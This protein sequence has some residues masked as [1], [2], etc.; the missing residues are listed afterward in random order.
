LIA[1][2]N[3]LAGAARAN[4]QGVAVQTEQGALG[5]AALREQVALAADVLQQKGVGLGDRVAILGAPSLGWVVAFHAVGWLGA[6]AQPVP[7]NPGGQALLTWLNQA[8]SDWLLSDEALPPG[9]LDK[10]IALEL[11]GGE[12]PVAERDWPLDEVRLEVASSGTTGQPRM[13][14]LSVTQLVF[15]ALGSALRLGHLPGDVWLC[16]LPLHHVGGLSI[17]LR[18]A[19][20][21]TTVLLQPR[22]DSAAVAQA[23]AGG[24]ITHVSLV[25]TMLSDVLEEG[26]QAHERLRVVLL[27]GANAPQALLEKCRKVS[28]PVA[29]TWGMTET[30]S[31]VTTRS[32]GELDAGED[33]GAPLAFARVVDGVDGGL[34]VQG[35]VAPEG[36]YQTRDIG[37]VDDQGRVLLEGRVDDLI[38]SGGE[39]IHPA[40][41]E[42]VLEAHPAILAAVVV[43]RED[44]RWGQ[45]PV[46]WLEAADPQDL[47]APENLQEWCARNLKRFEVP[48]AFRWADSLPRTELG[49]RLRS[50]VRRREAALTQTGED[51]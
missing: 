39:N 36:S 31:Q 14:S 30:A 2:P 48:D 23:M 41:V 45:R 35:P 29:L 50:E 51:Y 42:S 49:K 7:Q 24:G 15:G 32:P 5:Y 8:E 25:P 6:I 9:W 12:H 21:G 3:P 22:F 17:L 46:A 1:I 47:P 33:V 38:V 20:Y 34:V 13:V 43:A 10:G 16:C 26:L 28:L 19:W 18:C 40:L 11:A 37:R 44:V 27:G 4:P